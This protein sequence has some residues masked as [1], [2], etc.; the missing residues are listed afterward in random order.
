MEKFLQWWN[1]R[2]EWF[3]WIFCW[4]IILLGGI[5]FSWIVGLIF[6]STFGS[7]RGILE[8]HN[9]IIRLER[10]S[11]MVV[12]TL[13]AWTTYCGLGYTLIPRKQK[14]FIIFLIIFTNLML[15]LLLTLWILSKLMVLPEPFAPVSGARDYVVAATS[16]YVCWQMFFLLKDSDRSQ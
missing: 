16:A 12:H 2:P 10:F 9:F 6:E 1:M 4:P 15:L 3:R 7:L 14:W 11:T 13:V 8:P 5:L